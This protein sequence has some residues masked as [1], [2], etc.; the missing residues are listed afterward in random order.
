MVHNDDDDDDDDDNE[1][2]NDDDSSINVNT[3]PILKLLAISTYKVHEKKT[4][5]IHDK[6]NNNTCQQMQKCKYAGNKE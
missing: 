2:N 4:Y 1:N 6:H 3:V 5:I